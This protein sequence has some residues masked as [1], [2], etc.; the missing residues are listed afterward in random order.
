MKPAMLA[1]IVVCVVVAGV[2]VY[3]ILSEVKPT[4]GVVTLNATGTTSN[5]T[6]IHP[7]KPMVRYYGFEPHFEPTL[8][9]P[10]I[11]DEAVY[12]NSI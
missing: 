3:L 6:T 1:A 9:L 2:G 5:S 7:A 12:L 11:F 4:E 10:I 8:E